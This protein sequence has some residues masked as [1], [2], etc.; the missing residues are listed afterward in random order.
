MK[1]THY[2]VLGIAKTAAAEEVKA[3]FRKLARLNH[4]DR[5]PGDRAAEER[6]KLAAAAYEVL[7]DPAKRQHYDRFGTA[8]P[9]VIPSRKG[10]YLIE[11]QFATGDLADIYRAKREADGWQVVLKVARSPAVNDLLAAEAARLKDLFPIAASPMGPGVR[12]LPKFYDS[13]QVDD[14]TR[15]QALVLDHLADFATFE[16]VRAHFPA[17]VALEHGV[18]MFNRLLEGL[19]YAHCKG[20]VHGALVPSNAM[21]WLDPMGHLC[22]IIDW[23]YAGKVGEPVKAI[24]PSWRSFYPPEVLG[25]QPATAAT[26]IYMAAKLVGFVL[27]GTEAS[28]WLPPATPD[29]LRRF[30]AGCCLP[31]PRQRPQGAW[32]VHEEFRAYMQAHY[33]PKKFVPFT[34]P[35]WAR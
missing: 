31:D 5:N 18:W 24:S 34:N 16:Q 10:R 12:Y 17:G 13:F 6:F 4:P 2:Q 3:A 8:A 35:G 29:Y 7:S 23:S 14:G 19:D 33:G 1:P 11:G 32:S 9:I 22:K 15:R 26:D 27:G 25:K 21:V 20:Q 30:L 28:R